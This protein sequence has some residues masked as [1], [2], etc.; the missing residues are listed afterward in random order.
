MLFLENRLKELKM[1]KQ[2]IR[3]LSCFIPSKKRRK[4]FRDKYS[5]A[6]LKMIFKNKNIINK[7]KNNKFILHL[8]NG[9]MVKNPIIPGLKVVFEGND[10]VC[11][12]YAPVPKFINCE[13]QMTRQAHFILHESQYK[14]KN[15]IVWR[16]RK[17]SKCEIGKNFSCEGVEVALHG[18][19]NLH[20]KIGEE[21]MFSHD[22]FIQTTDNHAIIDK[23][24]KKPINFGKSITIGDHVWLCPHVHIHKG[25]TISNDC[26]IGTCSIVNRSIKKSNCVAVGMPAKIVKENITWA[27]SSA[28]DYLIRG[29]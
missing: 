20:V 19:D 10:N 1:H 14:L 9:R 16:M 29:Y 18:E 17:G 23:K 13:I 3:I 15:F 27:R 4:I 26:V 5:D 24:T 12:L 8:P 21:C 6:P 7:G 25:V 11:E 22:I 28:P 2:I